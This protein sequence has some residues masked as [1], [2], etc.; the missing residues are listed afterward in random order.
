[1]HVAAVRLDGP[2]SPLGPGEVIAPTQY[3]S[4]AEP[5]GPALVHAVRRDAVVRGPRGI[6]LVGPRERDPEVELRL[7][8]PRV[9]CQVFREQLRR[10]RRT[11]RPEVLPA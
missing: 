4:G 3:A 5:G 6:Q 1:M 10:L 8:C 9:H 11:I 2:I 7:A